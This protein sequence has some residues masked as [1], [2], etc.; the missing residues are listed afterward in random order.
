[1]IYIVLNNSPYYGG[2]VEQ[3]VAN[4]IRRIPDRYRDRFRVICNDEAREP[5]FFYHDIRCINL[6][7]SKRGILDT[8]LLWSQLQ[9]SFRAFSFL[10]ENLKEGDVLNIHGAEYAFFSSLLRKRIHVVFRYVVTAHD[11]LYRQ[12]SDYIVYGLPARRFFLAKGIFFFWRAYIR[13]IEHIGLKAADLCV[14]IS[15]NACDYIRRTFGIEEDRTRIIYNGIDSSGLIDQKQH[16]KSSISALI[17]GS[18]YFLKGLD[19]AIRIFEKMNASDPDNPVA[20]NVVGFGDFHDHF[21]AGKEMSYLNYVGR[22]APEEI[23]EWYRKSDFLLL[24]S[25]FEGFPL[26]VLEALQSGLPVVVSDVCKF[27]EI[28]DHTGMGIIVKGNDI[29]PWVEAIRSLIGNLVS[30]KNNVKTADLSLF[31]WDNIAEQ[32]MSVYGLGETR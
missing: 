14:C 30:F 9:F 22:V 28:P 10:K 15:R 7:T 1:M 21:P 11:S 24:P 18:S 6:K 12:Y 8:F 17:V 2:G 19:Q 25:R 4:I 13:F 32:Y 29:D 16:R 23:R 20:L 27:D 3:V 5:D 31:F 26:V